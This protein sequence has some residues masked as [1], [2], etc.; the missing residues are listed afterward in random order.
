MLE[1]HAENVAR[2]DKAHDCAPAVR[3]D[4][5]DAQ[6]PLDDIE[7]LAGL[8]AFPDQRFT[9]RKRLGGL[10]HEKVLKRWP[11]IGRSDERM[12]RAAGY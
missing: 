11:R 2:I 6:H 8:I 7:D 12:N 1:R 4:F 9:G 10:S 3:Q 5:V